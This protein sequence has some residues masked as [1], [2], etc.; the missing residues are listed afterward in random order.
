MKIISLIDNECSI[1]G[2]KKAHGLSMYIEVD[3]LKVLFDVGRDKKFLYNAEKLGVDIREVDI[4]VI[5][6]GH[7]D[8]G[9]ALD[10]FLKV[11]SKAKVYA[12]KNVF[13]DYYA[14][15]L[16]I[17]VYIGLNNVYKNNERIVYVDGECRINDDIVLF[18]CEG[19]VDKNSELYVREGAVYRKDQFDHEIAMVINKGGGVLVSGCS[20][21]GIVN[22]Y[23][24][25]KKYFGGLAYVFGGY[26]LKSY[27]KGSGDTSSIIEM[28]NASDAKYYTCHCTG[29][30][31][32]NKLREAVGEKVE[33]FSTGNII[34]I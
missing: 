3:D 28:I 12:H 25:G 1:K 17:H 10:H 33:Y 5:S 30:K 21:K 11:N 24:E 32:Y 9:G 13:G 16:G 31:P 14:K 8:H 7:I 15:A 2:L 20:H 4:L 6:H 34:E 23:N 22:Y 29:V 19:E 26:H 18:G 27:I